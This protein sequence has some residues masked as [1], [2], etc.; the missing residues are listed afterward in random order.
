MSKL[1]LS[2]VAAFAGESARARGAGRGNGSKFRAKIVGEI[3]LSVRRTVG[4]PDGH[5]VAC[6]D[7]HGQTVCRTDSLTTPAYPARRKK[8]P[9]SRGR[10]LIQLTVVRIAVLQAVGFEFC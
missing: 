7:P 3:P 4:L 9:R 2:K 5:R 6:G 8:R 10:A 1:G